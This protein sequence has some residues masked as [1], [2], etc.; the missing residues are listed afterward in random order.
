MA[1]NALCTLGGNLEFTTIGAGIYSKASDGSIG[2]RITF[3]NGDTYNGI[4]HGAW[5]ADNAISTSD[6]RLKSSIAPLHHTLLSHMSRVEGAKNQQLD[7]SSN[8]TTAPADAKA[9]SSG[10][11]AEAKKKTKGDAVNWMLRELRPVSFTF[12][13]GLDSKN[14]QGKQ[15]YGFVAQEVERVVP[16]LVKEAGG[17]KA[18]IYQDF[19]AMI[20]LAAQDH[21]ER[22]EQGQGEMGKLRGL[23]KRLGEKLGHLQKRVTRVIGPLEPKAGYRGRSV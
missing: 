15:R 5:Q 3:P 16:E 10:T 9:G 8:S 1:I 20:T 7:P 14:M 12:R 23:L 18:M 4:L 21:Q 6:R 13:K 22:I 17:H 19:I 2:K 11:G